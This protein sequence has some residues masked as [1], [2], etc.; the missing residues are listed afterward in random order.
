MKLKF[1]RFIEVSA[2]KNQKAASMREYDFTIKFFMQNPLNLL[3]NHNQ[4]YVIILINIEWFVYPKMLWLA[5][6]RLM[7]ICNSYITEEVLGNFI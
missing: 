5:Q 2:K 1:F 6:L 3:T 7:M 4:C